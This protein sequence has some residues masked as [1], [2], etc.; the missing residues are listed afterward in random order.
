MEQ[1][2]S[3]ETKK[4]GLHS[5]QKLQKNFWNSL[6]QRYSKWDR[7]RRIFASLI[8]VFYILVHRTSKVEGS[9][10]LKTAVKFSPVHLSVS[11]VTEAEKRIV[12]FVQKRS[13]PVEVDKSV[14]IGQLARLKPFEEE[15]ILRVG[16]RLKHSDWH[17][18][19]NI[20][21]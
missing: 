12:K 7:L 14:I 21:T 1:N 10:S 4:N 9:K 16:G 13:F 6:F 19:A 3:G 2:S 5:L 15:G 18:D 17:Y 11:E 20:S 8:R